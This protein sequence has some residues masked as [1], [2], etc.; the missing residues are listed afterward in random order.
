MQFFDIEYAENCLKAFSVIW[1]RRSTWTHD[2]DGLL[3]KK[4]IH[5]YLQILASCQNISLFYAA[6]LSFL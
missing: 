3:E 6:L 2:L 1:M 5:V 4:H